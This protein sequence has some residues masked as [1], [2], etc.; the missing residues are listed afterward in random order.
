MDKWSYRINGTAAQGQTWETSGT[1]EFD[2]PMVC[3]IA[4]RESFLKLTKGEAVFG[5]PGVGCQGP[6]RVTK[7][8]IERVDPPDESP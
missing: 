5:H 7:L 1:V 8:T 4:M 6:Y 3:T 2:L